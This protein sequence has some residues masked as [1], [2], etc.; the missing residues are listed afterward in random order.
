MAAMLDG[1]NNTVSVLC[2]MKSIFMQIFF[3]VPTIQHGCRSI[4]HLLNPMNL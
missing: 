3:I 1:R 2:E 4:R